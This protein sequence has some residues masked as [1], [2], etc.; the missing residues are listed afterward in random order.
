MA[1]VDE[2]ALNTLCTA[3]GK[4][5]KT[6]CTSLQG[7]P[8]WKCP[9]TWY[10]LFSPRQCMG[11][12][13]ASGISQHDKTVLENLRVPCAANAMSSSSKKNHHRHA[14]SSEFQWKWTEAR[15]T[16]RVGSLGPAL[17]IL[18]LPLPP[19]SSH[20][21]RPLPSSPYLRAAASSYPLRPQ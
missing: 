21:P 6:S 13:G 12:Q 9:G 8:V 7:Y 19:A 18:L 14:L 3:I 2:C 10:S 11:I 1:W 17:F 4:L 15:P 5:S 16:L 20:R